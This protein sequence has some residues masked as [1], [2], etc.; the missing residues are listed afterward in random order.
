MIGLIG[1]A[2]VVVI[3]AGFLAHGASTASPETFAAGV[4]GNLQSAV[5]TVANMGVESV[6]ENAGSGASVEPSQRAAFAMARMRDAAQTFAGKL[7]A[8]VSDSE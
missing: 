3:V 6:K 2:S 1:R 4:F 7:A 5:Q 8:H